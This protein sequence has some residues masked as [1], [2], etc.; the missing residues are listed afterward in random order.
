[1]AQTRGALRFDIDRKAFEKLGRTAWLDPLEE[2]AQGAIKDA[3]DFV[4]QR[5]RAAIAAGGFSNRWQNALRVDI[6]P[7]RGSSLEAAAFVHHRIGYAD[8][9][10]TGATIKGKPLLWLPL[11]SSRFG[12]GGGRFGK[13]ITPGEFARRF[14]D[15]ISIN[16]P[17]KPPL[18]AARVAGRVGRAARRIKKVTRRGVEKAGA[19]DQLVPVFVGIEAA[20]MPRRFN[21][22]SIYKQAANNLSRYF[23]GRLS[24]RR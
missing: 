7:R 6:F 16:R 9:F 22:R 2:A 19:G 18:L 5:G 11:T 17:G 14:G 12:G 3:G 13:R 15:L 23:A 1:M 4:K 8:V 24:R 10:E 20:K 21:L